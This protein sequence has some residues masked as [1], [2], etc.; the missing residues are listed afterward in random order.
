MKRKMDSSSPSGG[1]QG[2]GGGIERKMEGFSPSGGGQ[3]AGGDGVTPGPHS[4]QRPPKAEDAG[5]L[6]VG[7]SEVFVHYFRADCCNVDAAL[8]RLGLTQCAALGFDLEVRPS[9]QKGQHHRTNVIQ[10]SSLTQCAVI[11]IGSSGKLSPTL[12]RILADSAVLKIGCGVRA[13]LERLHLDFPACLGPAPQGDA[14]VGYLDLSLLWRLTG[15]GQVGEDDRGLKFLAA[16]F[17]FVIDKSKKLTLSRWDANPLSAAQI[18]YA[19]LDAAIGAHIAARL[20]GVN[21]ALLGSDGELS[22]RA[23]PYSHAGPSMSAVA[24]QGTA[25]ALRLPAEARMRLER[26]LESFAALTERKKER[27]AAKTSSKSSARQ[28]QRQVQ[29]SGINAGKKKKKKSNKNGKA[30][31]RALAAGGQQGQ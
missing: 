10:I 11:T 7:N 3:G 22:R 27:N 28:E 30:K 8:Q 19:A 29:P 5:L 18:K 31:A 14:L 15:S 13:D 16:A 20:L 2:A 9:F 4:N 17:D 21:P 23:V 6:A 24:R 25:L 12:R 26:E 1:G